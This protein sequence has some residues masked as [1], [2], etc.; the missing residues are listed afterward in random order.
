MS[1]DSLPFQQRLAQTATAAHDLLRPSRVSRWEVFAKASSFRAT[2]LADGGGSVVCAEETGVAVRSFRN[3]R[4]G[5]AAASGLEAD[6]ARRA[7]EGALSGELPRELDPLPPARLLGV[8]PTPPP[9]PPAS[10]DWPAEAVAELEAALRESA[11]GRVRLAAATAHQGDFAW[12]L[13]TSDG[14]VASHHGTTC[15]L[16]VEAVAEEPESGVWREWVHVHDPTSFQPQK[17]ATR[18]TDRMLLAG[19]GSDPPTET[20]DLILHREV[21]AHLL[22]AMAPLFLA[23]PPEE[24]R[25]PALLG[26]H[27]LLAAPIVSVVD[28]R[29]GRHGPLSGPCDGEGIPAESILVLDHGAP[30][31]RISSYRDAIS[32]GDPPLGGA[33]RHSYRDYPATGFANLLLRCEEGEPPHRLLAEVDRAVYLVRP[34]AQVELDLGSGT[35]G[36]VASGVSLI[37]GRVAAWHP[38]IEVRTELGPFLRQIEMVGT[39]LQ[40]YQTRRGC[41]GAPSLLVRRQPVG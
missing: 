32:C 9:S 16:L 24:D 25:L 10:E 33:A 12:I 40:W 8:L 30:R 39:D 1:P 7:V 22:A 3:G 31:H 13:T 41:V 29:I 6:A 38:V 21:A 4:A 18:L 37:G 23:S 14:F 17:L 34:A 26:R 2:R 35:L 27:G 36:L 15:Y 11:Q 20:T 28:D 5:F 19:P